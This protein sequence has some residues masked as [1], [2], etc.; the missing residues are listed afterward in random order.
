MAKQPTTN[1]PAPRARP[2][3]APG[4]VTTPN[5]VAFFRESRAEL[6]KVTWPTRQ[7]VMNLTGAVVVMTAGL[8]IFLGLVD[9]ALN[10]LVKP[11][12]GA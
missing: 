1:P 11:L 12:I 8:A 10:F 4:N 6:R 7:E 5:I 3:A 9:A 2:L